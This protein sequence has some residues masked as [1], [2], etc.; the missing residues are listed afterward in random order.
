LADRNPFAY[1][2]PRPAPRPTYNAPRPTY[3]APRPAPRP[4]YNAPRPS[5]DSDEFEEPKYDFDWVVNEDYNAFQQQ[6]SRDG[7]NT[8]VRRNTK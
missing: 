5:Y 4:T 2:A 8:K 7:D 1:N 3:N 6:E